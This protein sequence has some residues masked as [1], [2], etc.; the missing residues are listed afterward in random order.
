MLEQRRLES[1]IYDALIKR[2][3]SGGQDDPWPN[4][5]TLVSAGIAA[6]HEFYG[7]S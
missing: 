5:E 3:P 7:E 4:E 6:F 2:M 1:C